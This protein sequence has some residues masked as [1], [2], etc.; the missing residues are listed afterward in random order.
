VMPGHLLVPAIDPDR[1]TSLSRLALKDLLRDEW[2]YD[3]III[4]D[5][6]EMGAIEGRYDMDQI[7]DW[8]L[9][10]EV[11]L[12]L[13]CHTPKKVA[14]AIDG[15]L[16][17]V[18]EGKVEEARLR[19]SWDRI[20]AFKEAYPPSKTPLDPSVLGAPHHQNLVEAV[21]AGS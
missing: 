15:I 10:A 18:K 17:R 6:L 13:F 16:A 8:G 5:D 4:T 11:D 20:Q 7:L 19:R 1:P 14:E 12:F 2:G 21:L 3:G 9:E